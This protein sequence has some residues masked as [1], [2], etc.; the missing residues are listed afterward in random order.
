MLEDLGRIGVR[1]FTEMEKKRVRWIG[2]LWVAKAHIGLQCHSKIQ[3][4]LLQ[5]TKD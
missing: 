3:T 5:V 2:L 1:G 4:I